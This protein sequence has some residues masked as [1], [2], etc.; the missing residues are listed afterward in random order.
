MIFGIPGHE[1]NVFEDRSRDTNHD[2]KQSGSRDAIQRFEMDKRYSPST[3]STLGQSETSGGYEKD[4]SV[5][6]EETFQNG[7]NT[8]A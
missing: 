5:G 3:P 4:K 7:K 6:S 8:Y 1:R 2:K